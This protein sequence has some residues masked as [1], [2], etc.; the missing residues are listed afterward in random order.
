MSI[1]GMTRARTH[2]GL[3]ENRE[4]IQSIRAK[5]K[6]IVDIGTGVGEEGI[7]LSYHFAGASGFSILFQR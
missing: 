5:K 3:A 4:E 1:L 7:V 6:R 2:A